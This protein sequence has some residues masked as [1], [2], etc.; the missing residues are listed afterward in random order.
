MTEVTWNVNKQKITPT[1]HFEPFEWKSYDF[2][3]A[4]VYSK[5]TGHNARAIEQGQ[6]GPGAVI[7]VRF[8]HPLWNWHQVVL[9]LVEVASMP[10]G[11]WTWNE[12]RTEAVPSRDSVESQIK[13]LEFLVRQIGVTNLRA[14]TIGKLYEAG[15]NTPALL[16]GITESDILKVDGFGKK[17]AEQISFN[18]QKAMVGCKLVDLMTGSCLFQK[19]FGPKKMS[20]IADQF[21]IMKMGRRLVA[22]EI[23]RSEVENLVRSV[24]GIGPKMGQEFA[25]KLPDFM[26][27][28]DK[29]GRLQLPLLSKVESKSALGDDL[30][31]LDSDDDLGSLDSDDEDLKPVIVYPNL[32]DRVVVLSDLKNKATLKIKIKRLGGKC[33]DNVTNK[34]DILV[35]GHTSVETS[36]VKM[37]RKKIE[38]GKKIEI[39]NLCE[40]MT[41]YGLCIG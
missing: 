1:I 40:F 17:L 22:G 21:D 31:S 19:S 24:D 18:I 16:L 23:D 13:Q 8:N 14:T 32:L 11:D 20:L 9:S 41:K 10:S 12:T 33:E 29:L 15:F 35:V 37:A 27:F 5:T 2:E 39:I 7:Q 38:Q 34:T 6:V 36:K 30:G 26:E 28:Y 25:D 3:S 4:K